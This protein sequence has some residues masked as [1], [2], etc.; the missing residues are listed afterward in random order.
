MRGRVQRQ[1]GTQPKIMNNKFD[2]LVKNLAQATTRRGALKKFGVGVAG[3]ALA[4]LG[5]ANNAGANPKWRL[6]CDCNQPYG[7]CLAYWDPK[8][9]QKYYA[10]LNCC[11][12][13]CGGGGPGGC[14]CG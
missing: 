9:P 11:G 10:C 4:L 6:P 5:F 12:C 7:G 14:P 13:F 1:T 3:M 2:E 8:H